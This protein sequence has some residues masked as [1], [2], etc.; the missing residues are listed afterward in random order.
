MEPVIYSIIRKLHIYKNVEDYYQTG[1]VSLWQAYQS[2][3]PEKGTFMTYAYSYI[4]GAILT[5]LAKDAKKEDHEWKPDDFE[6]G[7]IA[8][9][10]GR[11]YD[12]TVLLKEI[13]NKLPEKLKQ[14]AELHYIKGYQLKEIAELMN[15]SY[16][17]V[18]NWK[19]ELVKQLRREMAVE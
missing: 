4:R 11:S 8:D 15:V 9:R 19:R 17:S 6:W 13:L 16:T 3:D 2:F 18:K 7:I 1:L 5:E 14:I 10:N 12:E